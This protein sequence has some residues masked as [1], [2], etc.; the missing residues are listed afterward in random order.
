MLVYINYL[1]TI[2]LSLLVTVITEGYGVQTVFK[3]VVMIY[4]F[5]S[6]NDRAQFTFYQ[7]LLIMSDISILVTSCNKFS[8]T[9]NRTN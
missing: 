1:F 8:T 2:V 7:L 3:I 5:N 6:S 4:I 9:H